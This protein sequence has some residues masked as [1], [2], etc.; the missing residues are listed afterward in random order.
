MSLVFSEV[1]L[2]YGR[3]F[4]NAYTIYSCERMNNTSNCFESTKSRMKWK[5]IST[6]LS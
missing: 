3:G 2:T 1:N 5:F 4:I 6:F